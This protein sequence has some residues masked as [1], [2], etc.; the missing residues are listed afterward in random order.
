MNPLV[1]TSKNWKKSTTSWLVALFVLCG[2]SDVFGQV[3]NYTFSESAGTYTTISGTTAIASGWFGWDDAVTA[4]TIP[5]GFTFNFNGTNYT[6][7]SINSNGYITFG[8]NISA[9]NLFLPISDNTGYAGAISGF[10]VDLR[11]NNTRNILYTTTGTAPN[12]VFTVQWREARRFAEAGNLDFQIKLFE[13]SNRIDIV[14]ANFGLN[15][16]N[17]NVQVGLRGANNTDFNN[18]SL[19]TTNTA[20]DLNTTAGGANNA[21]CRSTDNNQPSNGRTFTWTPPTPPTIT[22]FTPTSACA[23]SSQTVVITGTNF[24][25]ATAVTIGGTAAASY[26]VNSAT[27]ITATIGTGTTGAIQV[28]TPGGSATSATNFTVN[29]LPANPGNPTSNS[30]QCNPPGV[31]L[32][33]TGTPPAGE[34]W[35]WQTA[36]GG[37]S[38]ANSAA[39]FVATTSGTYYLRAQNNTTGCWSAGSGSVAI[40]IT[41]SLSAVAGTPAPTNAATGICYAGGSTLTDLTWNAVA[42]A[43]SYDVYFGAGSLPGTAIAN[44]ATNSYTLGTLSASTTYYWQV[45]PRNACGATSGTPATWTF[46]TSNAPC[47]CVPTA[48]SD[49][50]TG[51]TNVTFNTINNTTTG[52][53]AYTNTGISTTVTGTNIYPLS[54]SVNTNGAYTVNVKAWI[55]WDNNGLFTDP[56]EEYNLG[57]AT[58][59]NP[60]LSSLSPLNISIPNIVGTFKMRVRA[61]YNTAPTP[62]GNQNYS[63]AEDY[64]IVVTAPPACTTPTAPTSL[65]LS[66]G[67]PSGTAINGSFTAAAPAPNSYLVVVSTSNIAPTISNGTTYTVGGN[68]GVGYT[69]VDTDTNTT[70][71]AGGLNPS[72]TYYFYVYSMNYVCSGG[73]L[74]NATPLTGNLSTGATV[75]TYC[76]AT[77]LNGQA[78][79]YIDDI[80]FLGMLNGNIYNLNTGST[81]TPA[82]GG[83]QDWT[84]LATKPRQAQGGGVNISFESNSRGT[85]KAWVDWNKDGD[86]TDAGELVYTSAGVAMITNTFGFIIPSGATPGDYRVRIRTYNAFGNYDPAFNFCD[87]PAY[88]YYGDGAGHFDSCTQFSTYSQF[89]NNG[90]GGAT[91][92]FTEYGETEDYLFTVVE[93][94]DANIV[95]VTDGEICGPGAVNVSVTGTPGTTAYRWYS[96]ETG[97]ALLATTTTGSWTTP[98]IAATT[99]YWVTAFNGSCESLVRTEVI[100]K[101]SPLPTITFTPSVPEVCGENNIVSITAGGDTELI[102]LID[103]NFEGSGLGVFSNDHITSTAYNTQTAWQKKTSTYI[104]NGSSWYPAISSNFGANHFAIVT[105]DIGTNGITIHNALVSPSVNTNTFLDLTLTFRM[106]FSRYYPDSNNPTLEYMN[107]EVSDNGGAWT[108]ISGGNIITDQGYGTD[109]K[110]FS[111]DMSAYINRPNIRVRILYYAQDWYDGAAVDDIELFGTRPLNTS[112]DWVSVLPV[113]A[114]QDFACTIPYTTG[115]PAVT[116]Y[117]K[118]TMA[119]LEQ[120]TYS[121][122]ATALLNNGCFASS[123]VSINNKSKVWKG[124]T[125]GD[126]NNPNNWSPVGVPDANTCVTI[127]PAANTS[128]V[129]GTNYNGFGKTLQVING[130]NLTIHPSNTLTITDFV[131]VRG[132]TS[133][134]N[135]ENTGSLIQVNDVAN[136]GIISMKRNATIKALDYVYW[137]SPVA[138]FASNAISP[139]TPTSLIWKWEPTTS[140]GYTNQFGN[141]VNGNETMTI[142]RGYIV[143]SPNGWPTANTTFTAN[144]VGVPNNGTIL[145]PITRWTYTGVPTAGPTSTPVTENDDNWNLLGNPY[146]SAID[147]IAFLS[148]NNTHIDGFV[149]LWTHG[150]APASIA[151]P[152]YQ[153]YQLNYNPNDYLRYNN[154]GGTQFGF[155]GKI[156]AGQGFFV[157][158]RDAGGTTENA[159]FNNSMRSNTHRNDQFYRTSDPNTVTTEIERHRIWLK[160]I[161]PNLVSTDMLVGYVAGATNTLD[162][163][164]DA[165][166]RGVKVNY[167]LY[168]LAENQG[169]LIQG[170]ALPFDTNDQIPLGVKIAQN[171]IHTIAISAADGLFGT[172]TQDIYLEDRTLGI[173]HDLRTVPYSFTAAPGTYENRFVLKFNNETLGNEDFIANNVTVYTNESINVNATNQTIK[174]V[175]VYDLLGRVLG[176]FNNVDA[177][178]FS[179]KNVA[180]TQSPLL[181]EVTLSNGTVVSKKTIY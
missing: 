95:T 136:S 156:G 146:P 163:S 76:N 180:K 36:V 15:N 45:V 116:V 40:T 86:F 87:D 179:T 140:T 103:E 6:T 67:T 19:T 69:V 109:F 99:S 130:G 158:M 111:Y 129:L 162:D 174:S 38:T 128:N 30:P 92:N 48:T 119:Q 1:S 44:V 61:S 165:M 56:G 28:T 37:T 55:D 160:M 125:N 166:N 107:V 139:A 24:T 11:D 141:W 14:Y 142:G 172:T 27:Q 77:T 57:S 102:Y 52:A 106:Y 149:D 161:A 88:E 42:G 84:G 71:T 60:I 41:P 176:T 108:S 159:I 96:A 54:V 122:T 150:N 49:D 13:T 105:S 75:P 39:T 115:T 70:F 50:N 62:C 124:G 20:W 46:T 25:G 68:A 63:E 35:Y 144:F 9:S 181:V 2:A 22:S 85:W 66:A 94:C 101:I 89:I 135:I 170:R 51:I 138:S 171:G 21:T 32:T 117:I 8:A 31:T 169:L 3:A 16:N 4:N 17:V 33:R 147:A 78:T 145:R 79:R 157:L 59:G 43:T 82:P 100:A 167:E 173:T 126:W 10:G 29:P 132:A 113:D 164:F 178:A 90:C 112:F 148:A 118:P 137:S 175:R 127:P 91:V 177:T 64:T 98:P 73:P 134:F 168:S 34:T 74:Y 143:R 104:P 72:T 58:N 81:T 131:E 133:T 114:Y 110:E 18:R 53:A 80:S 65:V 26:V 121:F 12:R 155:D 97:G 154:T 153:D 5:I 47:V 23:S 7:C 120:T 123:L 151:D 93:M 152:F 83:Y